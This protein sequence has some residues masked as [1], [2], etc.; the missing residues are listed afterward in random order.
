MNNQ[1]FVLIQGSRENSDHTPKDSRNIGHIVAN[2]IQAGFRIGMAVRIGQV[3][4]RI[5]GYN[6]GHFGLFRGKDYPLLVRTRYGTAKCSLAEVA[7]T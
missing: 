4:G 1:R 7:A 5:V 2:A 3:D 6:I